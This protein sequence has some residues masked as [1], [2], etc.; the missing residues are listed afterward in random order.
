MGTEGLPILQTQLYYGFNI[1]SIPLFIGSS[2]LTLLSL[3]SSRTKIS[4]LSF[5]KRAAEEEK[6]E[7]VLDSVCGRSEAVFDSEIDE[8]GWGQTEYGTRTIEKVR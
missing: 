7:T 4:F 3:L 5:S 6:T 2:L 1:F 8:D